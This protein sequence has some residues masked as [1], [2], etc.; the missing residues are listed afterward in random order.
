MKLLSIICS[1]LSLSVAGFSQGMVP[2]PPQQGAILIAGARAHVGDG[3]V[4]DNALIGIDSGKI[5]LVADARLVKIDLNQYD[6][7]IDATGMEAFPGFI[8][9]NTILGLSEIEAVRAT[10]DQ[11]EVGRW[12]P[13]VR[14]LIAYNTDSEVTPTVRSNGVLLAQ[15]T[16]GGGV[17]S[18]LSSVVQLDAWNWEDAAYLTDGGV[19]L[20][21]P[22]YYSWTGRWGNRKLGKNENYDKEVREI[23][24]FFEE[25]KAYARIKGHDEP[26][27]K[28]EAMRRLFEGK[29][30]LFI[31]VDQ[32][33][34]ITTAIHSLKG[35]HIP[36]VIVGGREADR[37]AELL[38]AQSV[39]VILGPTH[40]LP[41][42]NDSPIDQPFTLARRL[43]DAGLMFCFSQE[44]FWQQRTLPHQAGQAVA[45]GLPYEVAIAALTNYTAQILGIADK[46]G[47]LST[48]K[49]A[50]IILSEGDPLDMR[51]NRIRH[52]WISGRKIDLDNKQK[53]LYRKFSEKYGHDIN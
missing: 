37:V 51:S 53:Q 21:W 26:N 17:V 11:R 50:N 16:P 20:H 9:P 39:P 28:M 24:M 48:G 18:G 47:T 27:L 29:S 35:F 2:A 49:D 19:H 8:A 6:Q 1:L 31:H 10:N 15:I 33:K 43:H 46:T 4:I 12:N 40:S 32:A 30:K 36:M 52:A 45:F 22:A 42:Y 13:S 7:V 3:T 38:K 44:G 41:E 5:S 14:S 34:A 23:L 25:A